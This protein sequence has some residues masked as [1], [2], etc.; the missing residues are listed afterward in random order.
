M[1]KSA[2]QL[3]VKIFGDGADLGAILA[4]NQDP[5]IA[6]FTT[7]PTLMRKAGI[8]DYEIFARDVLAS[9]K[10]KP[11]SFEVFSDEFGEMEKQARVI[12]SW[13]DNV[14]VKV[15]IT[16]TKNQSSVPLIE[17]LSKNGIK[18]N[19][20]AITTTAQVASVVD[21]LGRGAG[22]IVSVFAGRIADS[23]RDPLP[24]M[25]DCLELVEDY[26]NVELLWA[27]PR[28]LFNVI[29]ADDMGCHIITVTNDILKKLPLLGGDLDGVSLDTVKMFYNDA[30]A[31]GYSIRSSLIET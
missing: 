15:P 4:L 25:L 14:N 20:T 1:P 30:T 2:S 7:N 6:G 3:K 11:I 24:I 12:A 26:S 21:A 31:A 5:M 8:N 18:I 28:E 10:D 19:V 17:K 16:N 13:A 29:Q 23:G 22:G 27:S 9:V